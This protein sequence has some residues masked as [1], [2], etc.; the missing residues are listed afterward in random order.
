MDGASRT[1]SATTGSDPQLPCCSPAWNPVDRTQIAMACSQTPNGRRTL[2][3]MTL[4]GA[5][6]RVLNAGQ[7][8]NYPLVASIVIMI[9]VTVIVVEGL[10]M[11]MRKV[12]R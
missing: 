3:I 10:A 7:G 6:V 9:L 4:D 8:S 12:F 11:W 1:Q 5:T 2:R